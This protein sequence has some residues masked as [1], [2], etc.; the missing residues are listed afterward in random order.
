M[1]KEIQ[2]GKHLL[3]IWCP[4]D[5]EALY[6]LAL[7]QTVPAPFLNGPSRIASVQPTVTPSFTPL[8]PQTGIT[9]TSLI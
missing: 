1:A 7:S 9:L 5:E 4:I 2:I 6:F 8:S 3:K